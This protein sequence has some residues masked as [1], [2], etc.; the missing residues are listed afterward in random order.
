MTSL[1][2]AGNQLKSREVQGG[3]FRQS[4]QLEE[5]DLHE[6][7]LHRI[8]SLPKTLMKLNLAGKSFSS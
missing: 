5:I 3:A 7:D 6:N 4:R 2:L 1:N 8:P